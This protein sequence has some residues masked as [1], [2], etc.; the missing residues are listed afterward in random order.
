M[1][2]SENKEQWKKESEQLKKDLSSRPKKIQKREVPIRF[3]NQPNRKSKKHT[4][5]P[6]ESNQS[7]LFLRQQLGL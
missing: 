5:R 1:T 3:G 6:P 4:S 2:S 7:D